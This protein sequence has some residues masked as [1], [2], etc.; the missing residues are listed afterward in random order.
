MTLNT[1]KD[2]REEVT[3]RLKETLDGREID[4]MEPPKT[5]VPHM[6]GIT[7]LGEQH[8]PQNEEGT[9]LDVGHPFWQR[10]DADI[11]TKAQVTE[12]I[13]TAIKTLKEDNIFQMTLPYGE[14]GDVYYIEVDDS[15]LKK[16]SN[17]T[18]NRY[19]NTNKN[20][21]NT[22]LETECRECYSSITAA[23]ILDLS[24]GSYYIKFLFDCDNCDFTEMYGTNLV[25]M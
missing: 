8:D 24:N 3:A 2:L 22:L 18:N 23:P 25:R 9:L 11:M 16:N 19:S 6:L 21:S 13:V 17:T 5:R 7:D 1:M 14:S 15:K 12:K 20:N 10:Y 4:M